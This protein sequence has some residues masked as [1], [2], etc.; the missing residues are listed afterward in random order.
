MV[1]DISMLIS[2]CSSKI[3]TVATSLAVL[4]LNSQDAIDLPRVVMTE[5]IPAFSNKVPEY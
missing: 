3:E 5:A 1:F 2:K 4:P